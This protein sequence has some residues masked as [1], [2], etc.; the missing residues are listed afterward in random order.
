[1]KKLLALAFVVASLAV[2][3]DAPTAADLW[4]QL[5][6][7]EKVA[8]VRGII[9][10]SQVSVD[11]FERYLKPTM[12]GLAADPA[13]MSDPVQR[14][15]YGARASWGRQ[16]GLKK[17]LQRSRF[18]GKPEA[19]AALLDKF[20][21]EPRNA[22]ITPANAVWLVNT[23]AFKDDER[24][25]A[26]D[27]VQAHRA[28]A[29][30][31]WLTE[32]KQRDKVRPTL[33]WDRVVGTGPFGTAKR[34]DGATEA[35]YSLDPYYAAAM[36]RVEDEVKSERLQ[37][38]WHIAKWHDLN[39]RPMTDVYRRTFRRMFANQDK[40]TGLIATKLHK[41]TERELGEKKP[42]R[43]ND[44]TD[45]TWGAEFALALRDDPET[46]KTCLAYLDAVWRS[47]WVVGKGFYGIVDLDTGARLVPGVKINFYGYFGTALA[48]V[49]ELTKDAKWRDRVQ[50]INQLVWSRRRNPARAYVPLFLD[51]ENPD[52]SY[53][54]EA[55]VSA[56][57]AGWSD[58]SDS[59]Y[60]IRDVFAQWKLTGLPLLKEMVSR[61]GRDYI[62]AAWLGDAIG[63]FTRHWWVDVQPLSQRMY[64]DG[65]FNS[66]YQMA[67]AAALAATPQEKRFFLD[68]LD[69]QL[70]TF[71]KLDGVAGL[72]GQ[73]F[74]DGGKVVPEYG[75]GM[76]DWG[77]SQSQEQY[78][79]IHLDAYEASGE[80][81]YLDAAKAQMDRM[82]TVGPQ[83]WNP[84]NAGFPAVA[85]RLA[86][87]LGRPARVEIALGAK[88]GELRLLR[89]GT[90]VF[91]AKVPA[92]RT[93]IFLPPGEYAAEIT[94][95]GATRRKAV[96][97]AKPGN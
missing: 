43:A 67:H 56:K 47:H 69:K 61:H 27:K 54:V 77:L 57:E 23:G 84:R 25:W 1:M 28:A 49:Y 52:F 12:M 55:Q 31:K 7:G 36:F 45:A 9:E 60:Y 95:A 89:G 51:A 17:G 2:W 34:A 68:Y 46:V 13:W 76:D 5:S 63:H 90:E 44:L 6:P 78:C 15:A 91:K 53:N 58:D 39:Y 3:A 21:A 79:A 22:R 72:F 64:G 4:R 35:Y 38:A 26:H 33:A 82:L 81:K 88:D 74:L 71:Q 75:Y 48:E 83:Y 41:L 18:G 42:K 8:Q 11:S 96:R 29:N 93:V 85:V 32:T 73:Q 14:G 59:I 40:A 19:V 24:K 30:V 86:K 70:A 16:E 10:G 94:A 87:A 97:A 65:R 37:L 92:E 80:R 66:N 50:E 62:E 20:Y